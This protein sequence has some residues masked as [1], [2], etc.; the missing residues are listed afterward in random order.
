MNA[1]LEAT[2]P[3]IFDIIE[4]E[5]QRQRESIVLIPSENF[6]SAAV[7]QALGSVMQNK[8]SEGY[9]GA[10]YYG[11]NE[12]IDKAELLCQKRALDAFGLDPAKWG[13]NVQSLSGAPANLY[14]YNALIKPHERLMGLDLPHGG[15]LS[16]GFQTDTKKISA[17]SIYFESMPYRVRED[18]GLIDFDMLQKSAALYRPKIIVA[19]AS[20]Y[21]R[22]WDYAK[23]KEIASSVGA[24]LMADIAHLS[25]MVAAGVL[26]HPF[27]HADVVTTTTHKSLRGPRGAMIFY[28]KGVRSVD[29]K[30]KEIM[31]DLENP[32]NASVFPGHQGGPHNHTITAL[33]VA[34]KQAKSPEFKEYQVQVLKNAKK[35]EE[36]FR[37]LGYDMVSGGTDT[38]LLLLDLRKNGIDGARVERVLELA[39]VAANKNTV[40]GD[41]SALIPHGLRMGSP[42]MTSRGLT[43]QDFELV[44]RFVDRAVRIAV[45][46]KKAVQGT[47][48]KDFKDHVGDG[49]GVPEIVALKN[50]VAQFA[51]RFPT[52]GFLE[53]SMRYN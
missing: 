20:A 23:M 3:E 27:D 35:L 9:P 13:V 51:K 44:A 33:A 45:D 46:L 52:V 40:P 6:T 19:G 18:T 34:L 30:G 4:R 41:K 50:E 42:A 48:F 2:D 5:K 8:Y 43:E 53:E 14:V 25:G 16:H 49:S 11:G 36:T 47:K 38:H 31:Y 21:A 32:I 26:P 15:H 7:M 1:G 28:R 39:N 29:K 10:R 17:V 37:A 22:N 12:F 24:Y